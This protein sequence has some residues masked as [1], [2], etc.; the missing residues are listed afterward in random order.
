MCPKSE[1]ITSV[2]ACRVKSS[3][4]DETLGGISR[5]NKSLN[6]AKRLVGRAYSETVEDP[7]RSSM[8]LLCRGKH[9]LTACYMNDYVPQ[10]NCS[11]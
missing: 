10:L 3:L 7:L 2:A 1:R 8:H 5:L 4:V 9:G 6:P 11:A